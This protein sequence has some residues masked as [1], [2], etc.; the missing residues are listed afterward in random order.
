MPGV[1]ETIVR[2]YF[3]ALGF[4]VSQPCKYV[5]PGLRRKADEEMDLVVVNPLCGEHRL[6]ERMVWET[7]DLVGISHAVIAI[8]GWHNARF[9]ANL[10]EKTPELLRFA[11]PATVSA[12]GRLLGSAKVAKVLCLAEL[13]ASDDLKQNTMDL[14]KAR[15]VDGVLLFRS[16]LQ[17]LVGKVDRNRNYE[18]SDLLQTIRIFKS[19]NLLKGEQMDFFEKKTRKRRNKDLPASLP[20][21]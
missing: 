12:A 19:Y 4:M 1:N 3:E 5:A 13:P 11:E 16:I 8:R 20:A 17:Y 14:L 7:S 18:K 21:Q 9:S 2:E 15:G 6:P 10:F